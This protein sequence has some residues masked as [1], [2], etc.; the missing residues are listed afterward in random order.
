MKFWN[1]KLAHNSWLKAPRDVLKS[2]LGLKYFS[3]FWSWNH[4]F[5][6]GFLRKITKFLLGWGAFSAK[7][8]FISVFT[9]GKSLLNFRIIDFWKKNQIAHNSSL[10]APRDIL[11]S[12]LEF[13]YFFFCC[14]NHFFYD[15][16]LEKSLSFCGAE[17]PFL[18]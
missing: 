3:C 1:L 5:L 10:K 7:N 12:F 16:F 18:T 15:I 4:W 2:F 14:W 8:N 9:G 11:T 17:T 6:I 13:K